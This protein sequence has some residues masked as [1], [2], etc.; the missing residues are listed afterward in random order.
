MNSL[1]FT[2]SYEYETCVESLSCRSKVEKNK[3]TVPETSKIKNSLYNLLFKQ[4]VSGQNTKQE[5]QVQG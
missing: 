2:Y 1:P 4:S 3:N 5:F